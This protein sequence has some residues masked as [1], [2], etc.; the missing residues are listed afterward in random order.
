M[1]CFLS[2]EEKTRQRI[3]ERNRKESERRSNRGILA[4][5]NNAKSTKDDD[6]NYVPSDDDRSMDS[7]IYDSISQ[8]REVRQRIL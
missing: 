8:N 1:F 4:K 2:Q 7:I 3:L 6:P 5:T